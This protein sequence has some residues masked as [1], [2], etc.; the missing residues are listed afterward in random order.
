MRISSKALIEKCA[1]KNDVRTRL[2]EPY[3]D[4][5]NSR[6]LATDGHRMVFVT[7][8]VDDD[9]TSG[10]IPRA[11]LVAARKLDRIALTILA[12]DGACTLTDGTVMPRPDL[13]KMLDVDRAVPEKGSVSVTLN[14]QYLLDIAKALDA[15]RCNQVTLYIDPEDTSKAIRV[16][17]DTDY[18]A[19]MPIRVKK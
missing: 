2:N 7:V 19:L 17:V 5:E 8:A 12:T 14:A 4:V 3:L 10:H 15:G 1:G 18:A 11:A 13:G 6:L 9:D 16:E